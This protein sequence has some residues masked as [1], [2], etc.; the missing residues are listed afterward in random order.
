MRDI[1]RPSAVRASEYLAVA[2]GG[3]LLFALLAALLWQLSRNEDLSTQLR[4]SLWIAA[5]T[6]VYVSILPCGLAT[7]WFYLRCFSLAKR[8]EANGYATGLYNPRRLR[9]V[10]VKTGLT[11]READDPPFENRAEIAAA[12]RRAILRAM[13]VDPV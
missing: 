9:I 2:G 8:E 7:T 12:R 11:L 13:P 3:M 6:S 4:D 10:D 1:V 5:T